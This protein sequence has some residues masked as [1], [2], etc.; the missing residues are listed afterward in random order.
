MMIT[1]II[2]V[3]RLSLMLY[4]NFLLPPPSSKQ[5]LDP[6]RRLSPSP[7]CLTILNIKERKQENAPP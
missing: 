5:H 6:S 2:M 4:H 3:R 7:R 1:I